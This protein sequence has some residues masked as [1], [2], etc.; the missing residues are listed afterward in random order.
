[1]ARG[2]HA[3][4]ITELSEPDVRIGYF[5]SIGFDTPLYLSSLRHDKDWDSKT[6]LGNGMFHGADSIDEDQDLGVDE[7]SVFLSGV[8]ST[9]LSAFMNYSEADVVGQIYLVFFDENWAVVADPYLLFEGLLDEVEISEEAD[10]TSI[11]VSFQNRLSQL[12]RASDIRWNHNNQ[13]D[14]FAGDLGFDYVQALVDYDGYWGKNKLS[15]KEGKD[16]KEE[17]EASNKIR[18]K[19]KIKPEGSSRKKRKKRKKRSNMAKRG[20]RKRSNKN[21]R[22]K[23]KR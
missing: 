19:Y 11:E 15:K 21:R 17:R 9:I 18:E 8:D 22:N 10:D 16:A 4:T 14:R 3:N 6:W 13:I 7:L 1:M 23:Q 20:T 5:L 2:L 12:D